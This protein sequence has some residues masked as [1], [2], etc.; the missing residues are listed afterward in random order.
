MKRSEEGKRS[1]IPLGDRLRVLVVDD[2]PTICRALT[3]A[4]GR[5]GY[6]VTTAETGSRAEVLVKQ[7]HFDMLILDL[8]I[9]DTRGD[10]LFQ[11]AIGEQPHLRGAT[12][13]TTGDASEEALKLIRACECPLLTKPFDLG[14]LIMTVGRLTRHSRDATA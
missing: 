2:E 4:L 5:A 3:V 6:H 7:E 11:M 8:R 13:F 9:P 10:V 14:E 12:L 1:M